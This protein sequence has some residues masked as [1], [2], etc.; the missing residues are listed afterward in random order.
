VWNNINTG[1]NRYSSQRR[2][3]A[4]SDASD[5]PADGEGDYK[6]SMRELNGLLHS[7]AVDPQAAKDIAELTRQMEH[8]NPSR[9]PGNPAMVEKMHR[10][11]LDSLDK[12]EL[13]FEREDVSSEALTGKPDSIP[14]GYQKAVGEYY[15]QLSKNP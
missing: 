11:I 10:E 14:S 6:R 4:A 5:R 3:S 9:F 13:Q 12:I 2:Q 7:G 1:N 8:L 15:K